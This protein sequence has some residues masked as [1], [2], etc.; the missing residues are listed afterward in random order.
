MFALSPEC[1]WINIKSLNTQE[2]NLKTHRANC[3]TRGREE[4]TLR[5][6]ESAKM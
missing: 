4:A 6:V 3:M 5:Q 2:I 1:N